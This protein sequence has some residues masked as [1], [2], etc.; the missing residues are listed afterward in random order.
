[1]G[2]GIYNRK[3]I[4]YNEKGELEL[5]YTKESD[6][7]VG[8]EEGN[9]LY[10]FDVIKHTSFTILTVV[11]D[12]EITIGIDRVKKIIAKGTCYKTRLRDPNNG[13][14]DK[15]YTLCYE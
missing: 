2:A 10:V 3:S 13:T 14:Y 9:S 4:D 1:V 15:F 8:L 7:F 5:G 6:L 11:K 12:R